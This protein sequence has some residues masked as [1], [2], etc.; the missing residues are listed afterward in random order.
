LRSASPYGDYPVTFEGRIVAANLM[1]AGI[2]LFGTFSGFVAAWFLKPRDR[3]RRENELEL[4]RQ[5]L[6]AIM[7]L[8]EKQTP[9][10]NNG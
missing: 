3:K 1:V 5:Q 7:Q 2:G 6:D 4:I 8:L 9:P 10:G